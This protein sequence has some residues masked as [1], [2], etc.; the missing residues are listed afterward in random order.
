MKIAHILLSDKKLAD[1]V[2]AQIN[3]GKITFEDAAKQYSED[4]ESKEKN[5][6]LDYTSHG[7]LP[8]EIEKEVFG[9][10][11]GVKITDPIKTSFGYHIVRII[12]VKGDIDLSMNQWL[13]DLKKSA[14]I[15]KYL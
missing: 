9:K 8:E 11:K 2:N 6:E 4:T 12:D 3:E 13:E 5:G 10:E 7:K 15:K 14:K 1:N